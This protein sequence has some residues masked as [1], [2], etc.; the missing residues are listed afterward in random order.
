MAAFNYFNDFKEQIG[1]KTMNLNTDV[2]KV[3][4]SNDAPAA[5]DTVYGGVGGDPAEIAAGNGYTAGG[6]DT[7]NVWAENPAGTGECSATDVEWTA[8]GAVGP[9]Q[10]A[11]LYD[12]D[13]TNLIGWWDYGSPVTLANGEKFKVDFTGD[14]LFTVTNA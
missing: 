11:V 3:F 5:T 10:Y 7:T 2:L 8:T 6:I 9:F 4:L 14:I 1:L 12:E 13:T